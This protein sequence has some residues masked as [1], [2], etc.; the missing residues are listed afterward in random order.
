MLSI[1][2]FSEMCGLPSQTLRYYHGAGLL[3]PADV[4]ERTGYRSYT[5]EQ[6]EQAMLITVLRG[7]GMSVKLVRRALD[8]PGN[9]LALVRQHR[10]DLL[11]ERQAQDEAISNACEFFTS[12]P[13]T[14]L[15]HAAERTVVS[16]LVPATPAGRERSDWDAAHAAVTATVQEV[17]RTVESCGGAVAGPPWQTVAAEPPEQKSRLLTGEGPHWL[18]KVPVTVDDEALAALPDDMEVQVFEA[19]EELSIFIPGRSSMAKY[20]TALS[21]LFSHPLDAAYVDVTRMR[22]VLHDDGVE[23]A[24]AIRRLDEPGEDQ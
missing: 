19:R 10:T 6:V 8:E 22:H 11:R 21:R 20:G 15:R 18:V 12:P 23:T 24:A 3:V 2:D 13:A 5:F 7:T 4:D 9:A 16:K 14:R 1:S 17:V